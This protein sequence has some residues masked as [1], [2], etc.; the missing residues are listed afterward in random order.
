[1]NLQAFPPDVQ[2]KFE[3]VC[4][5][6][7]LTVEELIARNNSISRLIWEVIQIFELNFRHFINME[8]SNFSENDKWW[9][10]P[11][12]VHKEHMTESSDND[13]TIQF[14]SLGFLSL[15][16]SDRYHNKL[17]VSHLS[18]AFTN[19]K[20]PRRVLYR[21]LRILVRIRNRIAHH[22]IIYNYPLEETIEFA[23]KILLDINGHAA[24]EIER[25]K[26]AEQIREIKLGR[27]GGGI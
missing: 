11:R 19:W 10:D 13:D 9:R 4:R 7:A 23:R 26:Y 8:L 24:A 15:L 2:N 27:S 20:Y 14:I 21:E 3:K 22:E 25:N 16:L 12:V 17:W 5:R 6:N 1:M 18:G